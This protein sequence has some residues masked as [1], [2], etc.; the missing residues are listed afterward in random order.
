PTVL[1]VQYIIL[2][3][4]PLL[5]REPV[6]SPGGVIQD[7][8]VHHSLQVGAAVL[9]AGSHSGSLDQLSRTDLL[10]PLLVALA[11][12][13][14]GLLGKRPVV[15]VGEGD[16]LP[17]QLDLVVQIHL[18][19]LL[20]QCLHLFHQEV[21][22]GGLL[23]NR[24]RS[25]L[26]RFFG[27][28]HLP[29]NKRV[30]QVPV[31]LTWSRILGAVVVHLFGGN[32]I[33]T[34]RYVPLVLGTSLAGYVAQS[35]LRGAPLLRIG[36]IRQGDTGQSVFGPRSHQSKAHPV[37]GVVPDQLGLLA[38]G[39]HLEGADHVDTRRA[40]SGPDSRHVLHAEVTG[41]LGPQHLEEDWALLDDDHQV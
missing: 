41:S 32:E 33:G 35:L 17:D 5:L 36:T 26:G 27:E 40:G 11:Q 9:R 38:L 12:D 30:L 1:L 10:D 25:R 37:R 34:Y 23:L 24:L 3:G 13:G 28:L 15:R 7:P 21:S 19:G 8:V 31:L 18:R 4:F 16:V 6:L 39:R 2:G 29:V 22:P 14:G 20:F